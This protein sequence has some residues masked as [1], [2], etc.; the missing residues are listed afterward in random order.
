MTFDI[1]PH[2]ILHNF[3]SVPTFLS[4]MLIFLI[5]MQSKQSHAKMFV[6]VPSLIVDIITLKK[7]V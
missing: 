5:S 1:V 6:L 2:N 7:N 4:Y 3:W